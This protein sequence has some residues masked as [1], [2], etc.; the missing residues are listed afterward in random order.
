M[1]TGEN[2]ASAQAL[3]ADSYQLLSRVMLTAE[4]RLTSE[5]FTAVGDTSVFLDASSGLERGS[6]WL[7]RHLSRAYIKGKNSNTAIGY[8]IHLGPYSEPTTQNFLEKS[9]LVLPFISLACLRN[10]QPEPLDVDR[11]QL[12][13]RLWDSGWWATYEDLVTGPLRTY[14]TSREISGFQATITGALTPLFPL[15]P[16]EAAADRIVQP[17]LLLYANDTTALMQ[18]RHLLPSC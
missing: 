15:Q 16:I 7:P 9:Q 13:D 8:C 18:S 5:S 2:F 17:L 3:V 10:M 1:Y 12:W 14:T 4:R 6:R 11:R